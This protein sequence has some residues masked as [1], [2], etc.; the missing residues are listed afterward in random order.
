MMKTNTHCFIFVTNFE[1][2]RIRSSI[3]LLVSCAR[4][5]SRINTR[6]TILYRPKQKTLDGRLSSWQAATSP[7][8]TC[9]SFSLFLSLRCFREK[10]YGQISEGERERER[11][12]KSQRKNRSPAMSRTRLKIKSY[13]ALQVR[14]REEIGQ[15]LPRW[16]GDVPVGLLVSLSSFYKSEST[17]QCTRVDF[18]LG[19]AWESAGVKERGFSWRLPCCQMLL[20]T[21]EKWRPPTAATCTMWL[22]CPRTLTA[23]RGNRTR[24]FL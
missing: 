24:Q 17:M 9:G 1:M 8:I 2:S 20:G 6:Y 11:I 21:I 23:M 12:R 5:E 14:P 19:G 18:A 4:E 16:G 22:R 15:V 3:N 13:V 7:E 10:G